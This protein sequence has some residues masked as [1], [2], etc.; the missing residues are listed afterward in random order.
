MGALLTTAFVLAVPA[1]VGA[2]SAESVPD[3]TEDARFDLHA[4]TATLT[5]VAGGP[6]HLVLRGVGKYASTDDGPADF[7]LDA[8]VALLNN[9]ADGQASSSL[10]YKP[11]GK[12]DGQASLLLSNF[13]H[14]GDKITADAE[15]VDASGAALPDDAKAA[16]GT[17]DDVTVTAVADDAAAGTIDDPTAE[18]T[19]DAPPPRGTSD[20]PPIAYHVTVTLNTPD[21]GDGTDKVH[22]SRMQCSYALPQELPVRNHTATFTFG[23]VNSGFSCATSKS[24]LELSY[25]FFDDH[26]NHKA[27]NGGEILQYVGNSWTTSTYKYACAGGK[28]SASGGIGGATFTIT[29]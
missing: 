1:A 26:G 5:P 9:D 18:A 7:D 14:E 20:P 21:F 24:S 19:D 28:C 4:K 16:P 22:I 12:D 2:Q 25:Q 11:S 13:V 23:V 15:P 6:D 27:S 17:L 8:A 29:R 3:T 10:Q